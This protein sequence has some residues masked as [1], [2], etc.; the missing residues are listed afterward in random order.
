VSLPTI[1][2]LLLE[3][4][5]H[6]RIDQLVGRRDRMTKQDSAGMG[7]AND[8]RAQ[9]KA[10][11]RRVWGLGDYHR[12]AK[13]TVWELGPELVR[14]CGIGPGQRVL[15][16]AAGSGNV[17]LRAAQ[18]GADVVASDLTPE[19]LEAGRREAGEL[20]VEL[21]WVEADVEELPF[22]DS[23]FDVVTSSFGAMF[24][25]DHEAT[26]RE[27]L[28]VCRPGGVIGLQ[29]FTPEGLAGRFFGTLAP[30][31]PAPP[32]GA[33][34]LLWGDERHVRELFGEQVDS[35]TMTRQTYVERAATPAAYREL[36]KATFGPVV[37]IYASLVDQPERL[38]AFERDF[39]QFAVD[40]NRGHKG[41]P[42]EYE[43]E[44]LLVV[45]RRR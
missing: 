8:E 3:A 7:V 38:E 36:F 18:A 35:L 9:A 45:A 33:P 19:N 31:L 44:Y 41:G 20:G 26:A 34:P 29:N 15:D 17:A 21:E 27:L 4:A 25:P 1:R 2:S 12:F 10:A 14:T 11:V 16:V 6:A 23:A 42:A 37:A 22:E 13:E 24:A 40:S 5:A 28:R 32:P 30:Y 39:R 43:Y